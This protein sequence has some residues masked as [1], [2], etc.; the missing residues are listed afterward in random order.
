M[1]GLI[2]RATRVVLASAERHRF[3]SVAVGSSAPPGHVIAASEAC[4][5]TLDGRRSGGRGAK[6][7]RAD[8]R[9]RL[10]DAVVELSASSGYTQVRVG[11]LASSAGVS[12]ATFYELFDDKE[13]CFLEAHERLSGSLLNHLDAVLEGGD[14]K[15]GAVGSVTGVLADLAAR[16]PLEFG[17]LADQAMLAGPRAQ[18]RRERL[19]ASLAGRL[20]RAL[21]DAKPRALSLEVPG[22]ILL[23]GVIRVLGIRG[24]RGGA[25]A[26]E[27]SG[28]L[29]GWL[30]SYVGPTAALRIAPLVARSP[31]VDLGESLAPRLVAPQPLPR[32][33]HRLPAA[34]VRRIQRE[35]ILYATAAV[36]EANGYT[37]TTV[38]DIVAE[39]GVSREVFY[40]HF[41]SRSEAFNATHQLVFEQMMAATAGAFFAS[42]GPWPERVWESA[43]ASTKFVLEAPS[44]AHFAFV[45]SYALGAEVARRTDDAVLAFTALLAEGSNQRPDAADLPQAL[46]DAVVAAIMEA[47]AAYIRN[48]RVD[49]LIARLPQV[50]YLILAPFMGDDSAAEFVEGKLDAHP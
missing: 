29:E 5:S 41:P 6:P 19:V 44:F 14:G 27:L 49:E 42:K 1:V 17:F 18:E 8:Q 48:D 35:R 28:D 50:T 43:R 38:A 9:S 20:E 32:G 26:A 33:R 34:V 7:S 25:A 21:A 30:A 37:H 31:R 2:P 15:K 11:D 40:S 46:P 47:V 3:S 13:G 45:E 10:L 36:I 22:W 4:S 16:R 24:R 12:R 39:A 23:G